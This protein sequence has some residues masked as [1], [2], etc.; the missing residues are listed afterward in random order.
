MK[1]K[2]EQVLISWAARQMTAEKA[3]K[4]LAHEVDVATYFDEPVI[5]ADGRGGEYLSA[6]LRE[7]ARKG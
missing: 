6:L 2:I 5:P 4:D 1:N 7:L 3:A